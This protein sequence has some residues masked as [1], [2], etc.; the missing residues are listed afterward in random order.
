MGRWIQFWT[1]II[2][3]KR[4]HSII[5]IIL[6]PVLFTDFLGK[7]QPI[8]TQALQCLKNFSL[9]WWRVGGHFYHQQ[10]IWQ[11]MV[12]RICLIILLMLKCVNSQL[13]LIPS[14]RK[15]LSKNNYHYVRPPWG[16]MGARK[17]ICFVCTQKGGLS[18]MDPSGFLRSHKSA[19]LKRQDCAELISV[20][21][22][23]CI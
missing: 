3:N 22:L 20:F 16:R 8:R 13:C 11:M 4:L 1:E 10:E 2:L 12:H 6:L 23:P 15:L 19:S 5:W 9:G 21:F 18:A 17:V 14:S 7:L